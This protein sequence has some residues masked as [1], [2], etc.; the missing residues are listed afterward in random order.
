MITSYHITVGAKTTAG[1]EV[2][3]GNGCDTI[4]G[5]AVAVERDKCW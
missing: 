3:S 2:I 1:G 4:N 5:A